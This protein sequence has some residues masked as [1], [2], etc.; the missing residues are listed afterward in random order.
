[1]SGTDAWTR[2]IEIELDELL[3]RAAAL[4]DDD[5]WRVLVLLARVALHPDP[6]PDLEERVA[7]CRL[8]GVTARA[9]AVRLPVSDD[10]LDALD[11]ALVAA[12]DP[13]GP[14]ADAL[15]EVDD[16][17]GV[18]QLLGRD[19][20]ARGL[21]QQAQA[22]VD[23]SAPAVAPLQAWAHRR[24][25]SL[26]EDAAVVALW[27]A[28]ESAPA[29]A[30]TDALPVWLSRD[31]ASAILDDADLVEWRQ[32]IQLSGR[33]PSF[34][35]ALRAAA[36][37]AGRPWDAV[38]GERFTAYEEDG[39]TI[40]QVHTGTEVQPPKIVRVVLTGAG[41]EASWSV[42]ASRR[43]DREAWFDLG[44]EGEIS[45]RLTELR[46]SIGLAIG[47]DVSVR[48]EWDGDGRR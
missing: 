43:N 45:A 34:D 19:A 36:A 33:V 24:L 2:N 22:I 41:G 23:L 15:L 3:A 46:A 20:A 40:V 16:L 31:D 14:I 39:R 13:A 48:L 32:V 5:L 4:D 11:E 7:R 17:A 21:V 18:L 47:A 38:D 30:A 42:A 26:V 27:R 10:T 35:R 12:D 44:S 8:L 9:Q 1:M 25:A 29:R 6:S 28:V 37:D